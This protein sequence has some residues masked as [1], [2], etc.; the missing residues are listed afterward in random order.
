M[1]ANKAMPKKNRCIM[2]ASEEKGKD[3]KPGKGRI[4][5]ECLRQPKV[6]LPRLY[7]ER[8]T[9]SASKVDWHASSG[10]GVCALDAPFDEAVDRVGCTKTPLPLEVQAQHFSALF[11]DPRDVRATYLRSVQ[12]GRPAKFPSHCIGFLPGHPG[13]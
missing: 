7:W 12:V 8:G 5:A 13:P 3:C 1:Q 11:V 6:A 10:L 9:A 4:V 2:I